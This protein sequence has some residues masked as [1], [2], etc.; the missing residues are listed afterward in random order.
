MNI[1]CASQDQIDSVWPIAKPWLDLALNPIGEKAD[2]RLAE[3]RNGHGQ[4]W[5]VLD[6][7]SA[8]VAAFLTRSILDGDK[9]L[10]V[11]ALAGKGM[12][13]WY[14]EVAE[15][16]ERHRRWIGASEIRFRTKRSAGRFL[17]ILGYE[18]CDDEWWRRK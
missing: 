6:A 9:V 5:F 18:R 8:C 17:A 15:A 12:K 4:L 2:D 1:I 11:Y 3:A 14:W 10:E 7:S 16:L 13:S